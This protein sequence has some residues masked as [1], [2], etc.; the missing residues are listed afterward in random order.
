VVIWSSW[1][2]PCGALI[3]LIIENSLLSCFGIPQS[4]L[5]VPHSFLF[6][7]VLGLEWENKLL[8][9]KSHFLL[10]VGNFL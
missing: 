7:L 8:E 3:H 9:E 1:G 6:S 2:R 10:V 4:L 5:L